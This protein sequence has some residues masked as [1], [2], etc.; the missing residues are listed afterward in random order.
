MPKIRKPEATSQACVSSFNPTNV[1]KFYNNL[2]T[3]LNH[4]KLE[5]GDIWNMGGTGITIV[6][7]PNHVVAR[8]GFKLVGRVTPDEIGNLV[9]VAV[10]ASASGNSI[11][12][13]FIST[14]EV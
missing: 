7:T 14:S 12:P 2:E 9:T 6:Q 13:F 1:R 11:P 10:A 5:S 3:I 8:K 4:L